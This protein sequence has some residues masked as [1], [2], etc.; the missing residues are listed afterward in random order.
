MGHPME[1]QH[2]MSKTTVNL[3]WEWL[4][5]M[6]PMEIHFFSQGNEIIAL[7]CVDGVDS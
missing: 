2:V 4:Q 3:R 6:K 1:D 5:L 7:R